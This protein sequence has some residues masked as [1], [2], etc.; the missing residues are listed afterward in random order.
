MDEIEIFYIVMK[1]SQIVKKNLPPPKAGKCDLYTLFTRS[2]FPRAGQ[3][4]NY[5]PSLTLLKISTMAWAMISPMG[6]KIHTKMAGNR[7]T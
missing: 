7:N 1:F 2:I 5:P 4:N 6:P 3:K